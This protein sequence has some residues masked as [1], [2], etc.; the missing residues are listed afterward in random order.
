MPAVSE[1]WVGSWQSQAVT[2]GQK[3]KGQ[4]QMLMKKSKLHI[5]T[6]HDSGEVFVRTTTNV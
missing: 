5:D 6:H 2:R 1:S 4:G 3:V